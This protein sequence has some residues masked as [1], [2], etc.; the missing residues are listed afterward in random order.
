[1]SNTGSSKP[2]FSM[3]GFLWLIAV[4]LVAW[5]V[6]WCVVV[7]YI[8]KPETPGAWGDMFGGLNALFSGFAFAGVIYAILIQRQELSL[9]REE[10]KAQREEMARFANAQ[11][12]AEKAL[13]KQVNSMEV[14]AKLNVLSAQIQANSSFYVAIGHKKIPKDLAE[15]IDEARKLAN[16]D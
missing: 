14:A 13:S 11:E 3:R 15:M 10:L 12:K 16:L 9:Q 7:I 4:V 2:A 1:M 6:Y 5:L 8:G